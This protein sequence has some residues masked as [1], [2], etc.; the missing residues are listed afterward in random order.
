MTKKIPETALKTWLNNNS[1]NLMVTVVAII[2][3]FTYLK[4]G[5]KTNT[6]KIQAIEAKVASY[7]SVDYFD[8]KFKTI[9]ESLNRLTI[10]VDEHIKEIN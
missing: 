3:A 6:D 10:K 4:V 9:D 5:V 7:P 8:L 1:W 2:V